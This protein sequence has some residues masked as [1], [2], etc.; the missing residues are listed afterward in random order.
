M[1]SWKRVHLR[2]IP[3]ISVKDILQVNDYAHACKMPC[4]KQIA[5][6]WLGFIK[7]PL[8]NIYTIEV[9]FSAHD[10]SGSLNLFITDR[11]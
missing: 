6:S 5:S 10:L 4:Q 1:W 11:C 9:N 7:C 8:M 3:L 2:H